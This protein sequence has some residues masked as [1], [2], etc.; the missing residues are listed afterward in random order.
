MAF[1]GELKCH[2]FAEMMFCILFPNLLVFRGKQ[3]PYWTHVLT[4]SRW[5]WKMIERDG[6]GVPLVLFIYQCLFFQKDTVG[7][8]GKLFQLY[9]VIAV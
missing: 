7:W 3:I 8:A 9:F 1:F 6:T 5:L 2:P 4:F